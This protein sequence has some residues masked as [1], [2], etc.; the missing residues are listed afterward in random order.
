M[1]VP[2]VVPLILV[3]IIAASGVSVAAS[4]YQLKQDPQAVAV[5]QAA[6]AAMGGTEGIAAYQ[7]SQAVGTL[8]VSAGGKLSLFPITLKS[9]GLRA[10][11]VD[12]QMSKGTNTRIV[13]KGQGAIVRPD[14]T[15]TKLNSNN[16]FYEHVNHVPILSLLSEYAHGNANVLYKGVAQV[17]GQAEDVIEVDFVPDFDPSNGP[18]FASMSQTLF[19]VNQ[20]T[21][22]VDK[23]Q[24][25][26]FYENSGKKTFKEETYLDDYRLVSGLFV[27]FHQTVFVD[28]QLESDLKFT[29]VSFNSGLPD[30][31]FV[32]PRVR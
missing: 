5:A 2:R 14:G 29:A 24:S 8:G 11:R 13:N 7:D 22:L 25:T 3:C 32:L 21:K 30:S 1:I 17:E 12:L 4:K 31:D 18:I 23:I 15:V 20:L 6:F 26:P 27:P 19:F 10:T 9:K 28:G 16:T